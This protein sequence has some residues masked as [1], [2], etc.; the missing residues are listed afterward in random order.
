[1]ALVILTWAALAVHWMTEQVPE[2]LETNSAHIVGTVVT[3]SP[4]RQACVIDQVVPQ[5]SRSVAIAV[6]EPSATGPGAKTPG[7]RLVAE[8]RVGGRS[9]AGVSGPIAA[10]R[11]GRI[12]IPLGSPIEQGGAHGEVCVST[13]AGRLPLA[14]DPEGRQAGVFV[15]GDRGREYKLFRAGFWSGETISRLAQAQT[16]FERASLFRPSWFGAWTFWFVLI[17]AAGAWLLAAAALVRSPGRGW[18]A[19]RWMVLLALVTAVNGLAWA[20]V[21]PPFEGPDENE[22]FSYVER[23]A[24]GSLPADANDFV[25]PALM[26]TL[27]RTR[28]G[29]AL[30]PTGAMP[31]SATENAQWRSEIA[32]LEHDRSMVGHSSAAQY[33]P[34]YYAIASVV[35]RATPGN[36]VAKD[37]GLRLFS[38]LL[39][40][41]TV[42]LTFL[43]A[44]ELAPRAQ[45]FAPVAALVVAFEPMLLH[46]GALA[47]LDPFVTALVSL[48]TLLVARVIRRGL[49]TRTALAIGVT[50]GAACVAKPIAVSLAPAL[51]V[52]AVCQLAPRPRDW[53]RRAR[54]MALAATASCAMIAAAY[55]AFRGSSGVV[56]Q[57]TGSARGAF[58]YGGLISYSWQWFLPRLPFMFSWYGAD[59]WGNP[60]PVLRV[61]VPGFFANFNWLD[62]A[63]P[64]TVYRVIAAIC[65]LLGISGLWGFWRYR[66]ERGRWLVFA[67]FAATA[68]LSV[69]AFL[70]LSGYVLAVGTG[71]ALIQGRYF[72]MLVTIFGLFVAW[73]CFSASRRWGYALAAWLVVSLALLNFSGYAISLARFYT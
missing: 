54:D 66:A 48:L 50:F 60:P 7:A 63:F 56:E 31:W 30:N 43:T 68:A 38:V 13:D 22:H 8:V 59:F 36:V 58:S 69:T 15:N 24:D 62:T 45:W 73:G 11:A 39:T 44:R 10:E 18:S 34:L 42:L 23:I 5:G 14:G 16:I 27:D 47:H 71:A 70:L 26:G 40:I 19:R 61:I 20:V 25:S 4:S 9:Y 2:R 55:L 17:A 12:Q 3:V 28:E 51:I 52:V 67:L 1:M 32:R 35:Y 53:S 65:M 49:T 41:A 46:I 57:S 29:I 6:A 37:F 64:F 21:T 33:V 72:L